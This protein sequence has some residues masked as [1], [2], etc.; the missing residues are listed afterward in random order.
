M[1]AEAGIRLITIPEWVWQDKRK[2][3]EN[4]IRN[5]L[6]I[7]TSKI[8]ARKCQ[9]AEISSQQAR[10]FHES[11]HIHGFVGATVHLAL[12]YDGQPVSVMS[13]IARKGQWEIARYSSSCL[14]RGGFSKLFRAFERQ[15]DPEIVVSYAD[16][17]F[18][19]GCSYR[20]V[21]FV[22]DGITDP[23]YVYVD[24]D[25]GMVGNRQKFQK[26]KLKK[27]FGESFDPLLTEEENCARNGLY[28][29]YDCGHWKWVWQKK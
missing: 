4:V 26:H 17:R 19:T 1:A 10:E 5:A 11:N 27:L 22:L 2:I 21:G 16:A 18:W 15:Y 3:V 25:G 6:G 23:G 20:S 14:V 8:S 7:A 13:L 29:L 12:F 9:L 24:I 28:R